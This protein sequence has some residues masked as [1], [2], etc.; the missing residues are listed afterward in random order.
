MGLPTSRIIVGVFLLA[1]HPRTFR[2]G[3]ILD[4]RFGGGGGRAVWV[5]LKTDWEIRRLLREEGGRDNERRTGYV[6]RILVWG[7]KKGVH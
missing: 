1:L 2:Y 4:V 6:N 3:M 5:F 7:K